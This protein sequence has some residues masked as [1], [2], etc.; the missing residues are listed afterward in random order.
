MAE[1]LRW[2]LALQVIGLAALP[3]AFFCLRTLPDRGFAFARPLGLLVVGYLLW[4]GATLGFWANRPVTVAALVGLVGAVG[5]LVWPETGSHLR[6]LWREQRRLILATE[7][8]F[9]GAFALWALVRAYNPEI[10]AT[11][12]PMEF[13]FLNA[14]LRSERFPPVDPW[15]AGHS[16]SYYYF[17]YVLVG[18]LAKLTATPAGVAFN[19]AVALLFA[20]AATGAFALGV[21]VLSTWPGLSRRLSG[22]GGLLTALCV[23]LLSNLEP[24]VEVANANDL[25]SPPLRQFF[26]IKDLPPGYRSPFGFPVEALDNWW[27]FRAARVVMD[28]APDGQARDYTITEFLF[29]SFLLADLHPHLLA[30]PFGLLALALAWHLLLAPDGMRAGDLLGR[31]PALLLLGLVVGGLG[32][33]NTWDLVTYL[34]LLAGALLGREVLERGRLDRLALREAL[35]FAGLVGGLAFLLYLPFFAVFQSQ[36]A[37]LGIVPIR[38]KPQ[39]F[40]LVWGPFLGVLGLFL[41]RRLRPGGVAR[42]HWLP[43]AGVSLALLLTSLLDLEALIPRALARE[44]GALLLLA[45]RLPVGGILL[46]VGLAALALLRRRVLAA[47]VQTAVPVR[48]VSGRSLRPVAGAAPIRAEVYLLGLVLAGT[49]LLLGTELVFVRDLF[50]NRMNTVFKLYFQTWVLWGVAAGIALTVLIA[51]TDRRRWTARLS[52]GAVGLLVGAGLLY[53]PL[54]TLSKT[55]FFAGP[56][57]LD[58]TGFFARWRPEEFAAI[59]WLQ[60]NVAGTPTIVEA[61]GGS[62]QQEIG[63][64]AEFTGLPTLLGW[65][66]HEFQWRGRYDEPA[67]RRGDIEAIYRESDPV[68]VAGLLARYQVAYVY[69]GPTERALYG[70][71]VPA[72]LARD[73][74]LLVPVYQNGPVTIYQVTPRALAVR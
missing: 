10:F 21:A 45:L 29:F 27:W 63:R 51:E 11:E 30:L 39:H 55:G 67:R 13:A 19:L 34:G 35:R 2:Y 62:Y 26:Q 7:G 48:P 40:L 31:P 44:P 18:L 47:P 54:A 5:W 25:L 4:L 12:K 46:P 42:R 57:T 70:A 3:L 24:V 14:V 58:G 74:T 41:W 37:G 68:R 28:L 71:A 66:F 36:A 33:L 69:V 60:A 61:T 73:P 59:Q 49:L 65:D 16:I 72:V 9:L 53:A 22:V 64:I 56:P 15:L 1:F 43:V 8:L 50:G 17:G 38:T 20:L 23:V 6:A 32:F 52:L